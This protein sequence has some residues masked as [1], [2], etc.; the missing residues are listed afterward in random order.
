MFLKNTNARLITI[1]TAEKSYKILPGNNPDTEVPR[2]DCE[3]DFV[4]ALIANGDLVV[5]R[6]DEPEVVESEFD[7]MSMWSFFVKEVINYGKHKTK[8][9]INPRR[10]R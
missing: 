3:S 1:R 6:D 5:T 9:Y 2:A 10:L 8:H 4:K 7:G